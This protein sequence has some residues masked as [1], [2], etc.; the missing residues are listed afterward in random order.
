M[1]IIVSSV[2]P[3]SDVFEIAVI[4]MLS[5]AVNGKECARGNKEHLRRYARQGNYGQGKEQCPQHAVY[6]ADRV[7]IRARIE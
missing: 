1:Y 5:H 3:S 4:N 2:Q 6:Q 7:K